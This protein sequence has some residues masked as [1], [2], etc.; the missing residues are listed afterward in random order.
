M[1]SSP[2]KKIRMRTVVA[3]STND[4]DI[5]SCDLCPE[6]ESN[7]DLDRREAAFALLGSLWSIGLSPDAADAIFGEDAKIQMPNVLDGMTD[8]V[9]KQCLVESL[10][11][12]ECL[13]YLDPD[14]KLY[15]GVDAEVLQ[16]RLSKVT[17]ALGTI[18]GLVQDKKWSKVLGVVTGPMGTLG[19]TM[20]SLVKIAP[21][22]TASSEA[23]K[24][25][26]NDVIAIGIAADKKQGDAVLQS[27]KLAIQ[28]LD[29][30]FGT[31]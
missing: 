21:N 14:N 20:N 22:S 2:M 19:E 8:R 6:P 31:L 17:E 13:V 28:H 5:K 26:K 23:A 9:N 30:F 12:R 25:V 11:N 27:Q 15:K 16:S 10:G 18:P 7:S 1:P 3:S 29:D 4:N 24:K